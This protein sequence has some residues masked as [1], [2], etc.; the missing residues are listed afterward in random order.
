MSVLPATREEQILFFESHAPTWQASAVQ[1]GLSL[2]QSNA[3]ANLA[4]EAR[5]AFMEAIEAREK[6]KSRTTAYYNAV[7]TMNDLGRD[8]IATIKAFAETTNSPNVYALADIPPPAPPAPLPAPTTPES[9]TGTIDA[10]GHLS[11]AW[12]AER[13]GPSSGI[14]FEVSRRRAAETGFT[15]VGATFDKS[16]IDAGFIACDGTVSYRVQA[17]RGTLASGFAGPLEINMGGMGGGAGFSQTF[18]TN[19]T[20]DGAMKVAA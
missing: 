3:I 14:I 10:S 16:W 2:A 8:L 18:T 13:S 15:L 6:S 19:A 20:S 9:L 12:K 1:I 7:S 17:R 11:L 5:A 4:S